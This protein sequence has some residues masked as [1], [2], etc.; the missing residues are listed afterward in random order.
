MSSAN[1]IH[2]AD[3]QYSRLLWEYEGGELAIDVDPMALK[4][5]PATKQRWIAMTLCSWQ[6]PRI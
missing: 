5:D 1:C 6:I 4:E 3:V 2:D